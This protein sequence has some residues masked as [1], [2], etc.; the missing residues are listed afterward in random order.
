MSTQS[1]LIFAAALVD[2]IAKKA[3]KTDAWTVEAT[4]K[5]S[6]LIGLRYEPPFRECY[7]DRGESS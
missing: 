6:D 5:G 1:R 7:Y 2:Q 3:K 4:V